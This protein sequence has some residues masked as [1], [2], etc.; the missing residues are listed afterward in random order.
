[1]GT[2]T[3]V[4]PPTAGSTRKTVSEG[5]VRFEMEIA[6]LTGAATYATNGDVLPIPTRPTGW[7]LKAIEVVHAA[8]PAGITVRWNGNTTTPKLLAYDED[9]TSGVQAELANADTQLASIVVVL[10]YVW[11]VGP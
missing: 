11:R 8:T 7:V 4:T 10:R 2:L 9:N 1:M 3:V 5:G 6:E